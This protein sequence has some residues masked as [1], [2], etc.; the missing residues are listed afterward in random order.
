MKKKYFTYA[1]TGLNSSYDVIM[2]VT[3]L[4]RDSTADNNPLYCTHI[5]THTHVC[6]PCSVTVLHQEHCC[7]IL[8][9]VDSE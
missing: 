7:S 1:D 3:L 5:H 4:P 9:S 8:Q 6:T 2:R